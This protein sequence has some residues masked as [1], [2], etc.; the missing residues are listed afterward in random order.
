M[1]VLIGDAGR[2]GRRI[3]DRRHAAG[4]CKCSAE[5][6]RHDA[7]DRRRAISSL[8]DSVEPLSGL[9]YDRGPPQRRLFFRAQEMTVRSFDDAAAVHVVEFHVED[10]RRPQ[11]SLHLN[12][13][14]FA[15]SNDEELTE[16]DSRSVRRSPEALIITTNWVG[17]R[18]KMM[19][20]YLRLTV[21][22]GTTPNI[23]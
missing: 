7:G 15:V 6:S 20:S 18:H 9:Q 3:R 4:A 8:G 14:L 22:G 2:H 16:V 1:P 19:M 23:G 13:E 11:C 10:R 21:D 12:V 5:T 17:R